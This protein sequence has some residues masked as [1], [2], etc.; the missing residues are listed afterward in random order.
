MIEHELK[1]SL[2]DSM[3]AEFEQRATMG[4][5]QAPARLVNRYF[6][7]SAGDLMNA[8]VSLRVR[9]SAEGCLQT[10]KAAGSGPFERFEWERPIA[11]DQPETAA[12]PP[13]SEP[14]GDLIRECFGLLMPVFET[15]FERQ[16]RLVRPQTGV[17]VE[18]ACDRGEIRAGNRTERIAEVELERKEGPAAAFY[19]YA[20]QWAQLHGARL[21]LPTKAQRGLQ[22]AGW[23]TE[24]PA[25]VKVVPASPPAQTPTGEAARVILLGHLNH[26]LANVE[27]VLAGS[28]PEGP[29]QLRVALRRFRS[30][31]RFFDLRRPHQSGGPDVPEA[32]AAAGEPAP[33]DDPTAAQWQTL[34]AGARALATDASFVRDADVFETGLLAT[35][36]RGFPGDAALQVLRRSLQTQ[37]E[38]ERQRL[39]RALQSAPMAVFVLQAHVA[40]ESLDRIHWLSEPYEAFAAER[41]AGL[42]KRVRR[43]TRAAAAEADWHEVRIAI[44]NL[45]YALDGCKALDLTT[46]PVGDAIETLSRWQGTLGLGQDL[47]VARGV[48]AEALAKTS[49]PTEMGVRAAALIDGYRAFATR[50]ESPEKLRKPIL[51]GLRRLLAERPRDRGAPTGYHPVAPGATPGSRPK[52]ESTS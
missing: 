6:D 9:Q 10:V 49:A 18:I 20:L 19:H 25:P 33:A 15:D 27:P 36:A 32:T 14:A 1:F 30:A 4:L 26:F 11:G 2:T 3:A 42:V 16:I 35:L 52:K 48:A 46:E 29:H 44:K 51:A 47:A 37:R 7:T 8:A 43:R 24:R 13:A 40:I 38:Q 17:R 41:L 23:L 22:L 12:L 31:I 21:L 28:D 39:R 50:S 5:A 45:R 34:D